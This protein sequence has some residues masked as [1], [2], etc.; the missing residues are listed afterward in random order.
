M[1]AA[2]QDN[3]SYRCVHDKVRRSDPGGDGPG[4]RTHSAAALCLGSLGF[5]QTEA[6]GDEMDFCEGQYRSRLHKLLI[7]TRL[8]WSSSGHIS[9]V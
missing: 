7:S 4:A 9:R 6:D 1:L 8:M 3:K 5:I 2:V